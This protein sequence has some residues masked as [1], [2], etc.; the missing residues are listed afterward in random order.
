MN[1]ILYTLSG[2][3]AVPGLFALGLAI[4]SGTWAGLVPIVATLGI[5]VVCFPKIPLR[6]YERIGLVILLMIF[7]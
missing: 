5:A 1:F 2:L 4:W 3:F 7:T 6:G